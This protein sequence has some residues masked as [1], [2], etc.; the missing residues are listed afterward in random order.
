MIQSIS[1]YLLIHPFQT[2]PS[3]QSFSTPAKTPSS[4]HGL[5]HSQSHPR[6][7]TQTITTASLAFLAAFGFF[8]RFKFFKRFS[9]LVLEA[10]RK[11][12]TL[13]HG[14]VIDIAD[15]I[16]MYAGSMPARSKCYSGKTSDKKWMLCS[17]SAVFFSECRNS[18]SILM[19]R[20]PF[21]YFFSSA[22]LLRHEALA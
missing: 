15:Q 5:H 18:V 12:S 1:F 7:T 19:T 13:Y 16:M 8:W 10:Q 2:S 22:F 20:E 3:I 17:F 21:L 11:S 6:F 14:Q 4:A 9:S